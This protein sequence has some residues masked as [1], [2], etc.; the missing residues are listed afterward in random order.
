MKIVLK[1]SKLIEV[2][3][4][5]FNLLS[6]SFGSPDLWGL[7]MVTSC[8]L[9][10]LSFSMKCINFV[11]GKYTYPNKQFS[12]CPGFYL[13][14]SHIKCNYLNHL[15]L[16]VCVIYSIIVIINTSFFRFPCCYRSL[17]ARVWPKRLLFNQVATQLSSRGWVDP[18]PDLIHVFKICG[19]AGDRTR[20]IMIRSHDMLT[21]RPIYRYKYI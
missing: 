10:W 8:S 18:V 15:P 9:S 6:Q 2:Y 4:L 3:I 19:S 20:D 11:E 16:S 13:V 14:N 7:K 17:S 1:E 21:P 5:N 12:S